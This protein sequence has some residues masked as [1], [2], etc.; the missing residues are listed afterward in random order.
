MCMADQLSSNLNAAQNIVALILFYFESKSC[1]RSK[2]Y[3]RYASQI[4]LP[5]C[6]VWVV[7]ISLTVNYALYILICITLLHLFAEKIITNGFVSAS[8]QLSGYL[9][10]AIF[11]FTPVDCM[12]FNSDTFNLKIHLIKVNRPIK[13]NNNRQSPINNGLAHFMF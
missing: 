1:V 12:A 4:S 9:P 10:C 13:I 11:P 2:L 3:Q 8:K 7:P 6:A 5:S